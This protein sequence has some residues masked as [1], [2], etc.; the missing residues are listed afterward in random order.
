MCA[1]EYLRLEKITQN[2]VCSCRKWREGFVPG[3]KMNDLKMQLLIKMNNMKNYYFR[4]KPSKFTYTKE[5]FCIK[6]FYNIQAWSLSSSDQRDNDAGVNEWWGWLTGCL[7][8]M[9]G[10]G[11][12]R[13]Q[14][15]AEK[16][17]WRA[18]KE[19]QNSIVVY[20]T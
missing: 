8:N 6:K 15:K 16:R 17:T 11:E 7:M 10:K 20:F 9:W 13:S 1:I 2:G 5:F 3:I 19:K 12:E 14:T 18:R 4:T